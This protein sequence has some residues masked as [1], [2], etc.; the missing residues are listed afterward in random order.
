MTWLS[1]ALSDI[2]YA[3]RALARRPAFTVVAALTLALGIATATAM[4]TLVD[5]I[6]LRPLPYTRSDRLVE[7][8]QSYPEKKLDRW[9]LSQE[10][11]ATYYGVKS[12]AAFAAYVRTG[13]TLDDDG[14]AD[15]AIAEAVTGDF[16]SLLG[17]KPML[18]RVLGREDDQKNKNDGVVLSYGFWQT[19]F[20]GSPN[21][22]GRTI[23]IDGSPARVVGVLP[24]GFAFPRSDVQVYTALALDPTR[25][26]PNFL[27]GIARLRDGA[28][29][30]QAEHEATLTMWNWAR[31]APGVLNGTPVEKTHMHVIITPLRAAVAGSVAKPLLVLQTAVAL[32]LLIAIA[33]IAT[34][35]GARGVGRTREIAVR[36]ALGATRRRLV[37]QMI[38]ESLALAMVGGVIGVLATVVLVRAFAHSSLA[39]LPRVD[40]VTVDARV[41]AFAV[42]TTVLSGVLFGL[43]PALSVKTDRLNDALSGQKSSAGRS[44]RAM[45][46]LLIAGQVALSFVLLVGAGLVLKSF[47]RLVD[48]NLGFEPTNV[49]AI[50]IPLPVQR[51]ASKNQPRAFAFVDQT[52]AGVAAQPGVTAAAAMFPGMYVNDVN[53]DGFLVEGQDP[54]G[55]IG[56]TVQYAVTPGFFSTLRIP[57]LAGR[58]LAKSDRAETPPVV[59]VD[60]ALIAKTWR[61]S[62]AVGKRIRMTGDT[63]WRTIVGVAGSIRDEGVSDVPRPHT[64]FPF[65]QYGT[66][67]PTIVVRSETDPATIIATTRRVVSTIDPGVPLDTPHR[68]AASI[69]DS[70]TTRRITELLLA[71][72]AALAMLLAGCGLYGVMS[73]YVANRR[74]EFGIRAAIGARPGALV[75]VVMSE[76]LALVT[77]GASVGLIASLL[78][79]RS[80]QSLL[81]EVAPTDA[82]V[83]AGVATLLVAVATVACYVPARR[84]AA[85]D[86][87]SALRVD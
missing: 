23:Q 11:A 58:D 83:Y 3:V 13:V 43:V 44:S 87:S 82:T 2:R 24:H 86:P 10:N 49:M 56:Q 80:L 34:L 6:V 42:T 9:T 60:Q 63:I 7:V 5:G 54:N 38:N 39:A 46:N 21:I 8:M 71:G 25:A 57:L 29:L 70:L 67:R 19:R 77:A 26:H 17:V 51:Y 28:T 1:I 81:F 35:L 84:A 59:V 22:V 36:S 37:A 52:V 68:I 73:L 12:F 61:P 72:F 45:N 41:L 53:S 48:T 16:F 30:E 64:Y 20:G 55:P 78:I 27:N 85:S 62:E 4:F 75:Q 69:A 74:R 14:Q 65:A 76:A 33:N 66:I 79:G 15:R 18:G 50:P 32:I 40:E 47:R 31:R